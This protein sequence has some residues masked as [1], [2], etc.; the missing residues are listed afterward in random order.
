M[1]R[2]A[3][4]LLLAL[5]F[6]FAAAATGCS[7]PE[8]VASQ[9]PGSEST[10]PA[11]DEKVYEISFAHFFP[12]THPVHLRHEAWAK[13]LEEKSDGR[14]KIVFHYGETLLKAAETY[15]GVKSKVADMGLVVPS[16]TPGLFPMTELYEL[17]VNNNNSQVI[18]RVFWEVYQK[19]Q[20]AEWNEVKVLS[21]YGIGPGGVATKK[22][23]ETLEQLRGMQI[24]ATGTCASYMQALGAAPVSITMPESYE[25]VSRG[26]CDGV[27]N[28]WDAF[29]T[30]KLVEV[31]DS[32]TMTPFLYASPFVM[33]MNQ[34]TW[35]GLPEDLQKIFEEV[36]QDFIDY[37]ATEEANNAVTSVQAILDAEK[38]IVVLSDEEE[39]RWYEAAMSAVQS[40]IDARADKGPAQEVYDTMV[41][42]AEKYNGE[43]P[44]LRDAVLQ[45]IDGAQ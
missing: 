13:E 14:I 29:I 19:Y 41:E 1:K 30:W 16:Y 34:D 27:L 3:L 12:A 5:A 20:P 10:G 15:E 36:S 6:V 45:Q 18:S 31:A 24:R 2:R 22:P 28:A 9:K 43:Y 44:A 11:A 4:A 25:A 35:N 23:V 8:G 17:P 42:L 33:V 26:T 40:A 7:G 39:T 38:S 32:F 37:H 21:I